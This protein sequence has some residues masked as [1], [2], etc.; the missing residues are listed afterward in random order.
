VIIKKEHF[1]EWVERHKEQSNCS[2]IDAVLDACETFKISESL[3]KELL[4]IQIISKIEAEARNLN[5]IKRTSFS[6][7]SFL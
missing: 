1:S 5:F 6:I 2:Y 7:S 3:C 4:N